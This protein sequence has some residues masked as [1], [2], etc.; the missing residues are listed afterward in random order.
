MSA[1]P[2]KYLRL[3]DGRLGLRRF[4][5]HER[6][7]TTLLCF[8]YAGG[9][10]LAFKSLSEHLPADWAAWAIDPPGHG[11]AAAP[12]LDRVEQMVDLYLELLPRELV[13]G[14]LLLGH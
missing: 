7:G 8:P 2:P 14:A 3:A 13:S 9:Q 1:A 5:D 12:P 11:W 4:H 10:S 6:R